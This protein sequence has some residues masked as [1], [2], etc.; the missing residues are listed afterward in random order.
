MFHLYEASFAHYLRKFSNFQEWLDNNFFPIQ[1]GT[2]RFQLV[3]DA[4]K[5]VG[6]SLIYSKV[7]SS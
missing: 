7:L 2:D 1:T 5:F 6:P 3:T 4:S